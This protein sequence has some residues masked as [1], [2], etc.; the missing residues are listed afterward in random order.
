MLLKIGLFHIFMVPILVL[1]QLKFDGVQ[2]AS[3]TS[4]NGTN[5][6]TNNDTLDT[7]SGANKVNEDGT[8]GLLANILSKLKNRGYFQKFAV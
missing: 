6:I 7:R 2:Q 8:S 1:G 4:D 5:K 3:A